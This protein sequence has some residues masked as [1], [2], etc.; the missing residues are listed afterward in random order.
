MAAIQTSIL[1]KAD[2]QAIHEAALRVLR[3]TG[4]RVHHDFVLAQLQE[5][6]A[7]VDASQQ[8]ARFPEELVMRC[9]QQAGKSYVLHGRDPSRVARF[10][11]GDLNLMSSPGQCAWLDFE[12]GSL[13]AP[14][15]EDTRSGIRLGD[16]LPNV[17][18]VGAFAQPPDLASGF[19]DVLLASELVRGSTKP[20]R[21]WVHNG[22]SARHVLEIYRTVAG[23][24]ENLRLRPM[25]ETFLEPISPLQMPHDGLDAVIEFVRAGQ[26]VSI[27]PMSMASGT[28]P[29]TLAG[30]LV[31]EHAEILAG[32]TIVQTLEPGA[33]VLYGGIPHIMDP[34]TSICSFGSP[35]QGLL[36]VGMAQLGR[37]LGFAVYLNIGLTDAKTLDAQAGFEKASS[38]ILGALAGADLA[39]HAGI[40][41]P[42]HAASLEWL[43][44]D[45]ELMSFLRRVRR[46]FEVS[47]ETLAAEVIAAVGPGG[48]YLAEEH[49]LQNFR[50]ELWIPGSPWTRQ[51][52][53]AWH[54]AGRQSMADRVHTRAGE[55]LAKHQVPPLDPGLSAE[56]EQIVI[57][58]RN[59]QV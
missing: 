41:G 43:V 19:S 22:R 37:S 51:G 12:T 56:I 58:A 59:E 54:E 15:L 30:A 21:C 13:R 14:T 52:W 44:L 47:S 53:K 4:V 42:D 36:A 57:S 2:I 25:T 48:N 46:G 27:N 9:V 28:A 50:R 16:A 1:S 39:G 31:L 11:H 45:D 40:C 34:R 7:E 18:I 35:E 33:P 55:L 3:D 32:I 24:S 49:T 10:G 23:G 6:G 38:L 5:Q 20:T 26:P 17:T 8:M 29:A